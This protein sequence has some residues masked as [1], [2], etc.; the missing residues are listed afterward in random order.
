MAILGYLLLSV[1]IIRSLASGIGILIAAFRESPI[2]GIGCLLL[3][4]AAF[5]FVFLHWAE[6][7]KFFTMNV[8]GIAGVILGALFV[9]AGRS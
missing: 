1:G 8:L 6:T 9:G 5:V 3:P 2:W 7:K 4:F